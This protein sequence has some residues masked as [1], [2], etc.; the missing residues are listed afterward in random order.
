MPPTT[1]RPSAVA[2]R[3]THPGAH[4]AC[5]ATRPAPIAQGVAPRQHRS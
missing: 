5:A 1:P 3:S 4:A 2:P